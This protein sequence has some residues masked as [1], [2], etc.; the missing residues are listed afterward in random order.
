MG[1]ASL[2]ETVVPLQTVTLFLSS[3]VCTVCNS[4]QSPGQFGRAP[5]PLLD[6]ASGRSERLLQS[7]RDAVLTSGRSRAPRAEFGLSARGDL[8]E[9]NGTYPFKAVSH[10]DH[11]SLDAKVTRWVS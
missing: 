2:K 6:G 1:S 4:E 8:N 7:A 10:R 3:R 11:A 5:I 9:A